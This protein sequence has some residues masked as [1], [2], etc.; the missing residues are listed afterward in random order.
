M[1]WIPQGMIN[2]ATYVPRSMISGPGER[3][4]IWVQGCSLGCEGCWN[5]EMQPFKIKTLISTAELYK[6]II[7]ELELE[8]IT[9]L[10]GEPLHQ[11]KE[12]LSLVKKIKNRGL[13]V[14][15][16][17]GYEIDEI[18]DSDAIELVRNSDIVIPSRFVSEKRNT[19][20]KWRGSSNQ[21]I[22]FNNNKYNKIYSKLDEEN[23]VEIHID[24]N[25]NIRILGY[26]NNEL[27]EGVLYG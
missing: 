25:G 20:L 11:S 8:G 12:L 6:L 16:Y 15:L 3:F 26:P 18:N 14:M 4:V 27:I 24:E 5:P 1:I 7:T 22:L 13:T 17:T 21:K 23:Q 10:G 9:L 19:Y 2:I